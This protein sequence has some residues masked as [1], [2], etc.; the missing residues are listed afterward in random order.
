[1]KN[2]YEILEIKET[3]SEEVIKAAYKALVKKNHPDNYR[4]DSEMMEKNMLLINEAYEVLSDREKRRIYDTE[5]RK[6]NEFVASN[7]DMK[8]SDS[9]D[10]SEKKG[11][12]QKSK[13]KIILSVLGI[14]GSGIVASINQAT[15]TFDNAYMEGMRMDEQMLVRRYKSATGYKRGG[16][17]KA[18]EE[19]GLLCRNEKGEYSPTYKMKKYL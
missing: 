12:T 7:N 10:E 6:N 5:C 16:Y 13:G 4:G 9:E 8:K 18:L 14:I 2:Y 11:N 1:M 19:R 15:Q 3:A 17:A